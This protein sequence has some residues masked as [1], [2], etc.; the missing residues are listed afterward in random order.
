MAWLWRERRGGKHGS[1]VSSRSY[2]NQAQRGV[3]LTGIICSSGGKRH[4]SSALGNNKAAMARE[5]ASY[6][7][8]RRHRNNVAEKQRNGNGA[9]AKMK[10]KLCEKIVNRH[11]SGISM[12]A[13]IVA[14]VICSNNGEKHHQ[15][16]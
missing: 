13:G 16:L 2:R 10:N 15:F 5:K 3:N 6:Q 9:S 7:K 12:A 14:I 11:L 8:W 1:K 4:R